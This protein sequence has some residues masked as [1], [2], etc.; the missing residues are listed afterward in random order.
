VLYWLADH[1]ALIMFVTM[2]VA[3]FCGYPVAFVMGGMALVFALA[4]TL[5]GVFSL[6]G[7]SDV[8]LR[9]WGAS[10]PIRCSRR[11]PCSSSWGQSWSAP[12]RPW[13]C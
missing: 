2:F 1:L 12:A 11:F 10:P 9:M 4:G 3:I 6:I 13:T 5:L 7:L 8:V